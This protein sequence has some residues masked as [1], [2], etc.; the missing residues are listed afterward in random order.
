MTQFLQ[1]WRTYYISFIVFICVIGSDCWFDWKKLWM[2]IELTEFWNVAGSGMLSSS[3]GA[4]EHHSYA[5]TPLMFSPIHTP[6]LRSPQGQSPQPQS[7]QPQS[8]RSQSP[9]L[10]LQREWSHRSVTPRLNP[11]VESTGVMT[12]HALIQEQHK[13]P[14]ELKLNIT[15]SELVVLENTAVW[16]TSAVILK[17]GGISS[18]GNLL[19]D[20]V[21]INIYG[22]SHADFIENFW[23]GSFCIILQFRFLLEHSSHQLP[24]TTPRTASVMQLEPVWVVLVYIRPGRWHCS[25]HYWPCHYQHRS[26]WQI[27][28]ASASGH[29]Q[30]V[31]GS[32]TYCWGKSFKTDILFIIK[33]FLLAKLLL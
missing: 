32:A 8:P 23:K 9:S 21:I 13:V 17:V 3:P 24:T 2:T 31:Y 19:S 16:D 6:I 29:I 18:L 14:F 30:C 11:M 5:A 28:A 10:G 1:V 33:Y 4:S 26:Q 20:F 7:P 22:C 15:D 25:F 27:R 12:K